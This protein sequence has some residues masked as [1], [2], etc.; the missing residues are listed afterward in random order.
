MR[1][2]K[3]RNLRIVEENKYLNTIESKNIDKKKPKL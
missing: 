1:Q 3:K 2:A